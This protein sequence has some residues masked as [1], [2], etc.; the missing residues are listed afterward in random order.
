MS[1]YA[2]TGSDLPFTTT[3][4][5]AMDRAT[6]TPMLAAA[7]DAWSQVVAALLDGF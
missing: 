1:T 4:V 6:G 5:A 2:G 7:T 3:Q